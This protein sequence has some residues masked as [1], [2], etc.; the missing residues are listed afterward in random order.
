M[1][2]LLAGLCL[3]LA[4]TGPVAAEAPE[5]DA[6]IVARGVNDYIRPAMAR[7]ADDALALD[8]ATTLFCAAPSPATRQPLD[9]AFE[10]TVRGWS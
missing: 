9:D 10:A 4:L 3:A 8:G 1:R 2:R 6:A 7:F 5:R